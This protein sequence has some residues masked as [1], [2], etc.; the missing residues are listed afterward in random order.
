MLKQLKVK[1]TFPQICH[2][3]IKLYNVKILSRV[4]ISE[5]TQWKWMINIVVLFYI[6]TPVLF[7][8]L[9][10]PLPLYLFSHLSAFLI[11]SGCFWLRTNHFTSRSWA[12]PLLC[13]LTTRHHHH[14]TTRFV[15]LKENF[16][17]ASCVDMVFKRNVDGLRWI[18]VILFISHR[19]ATLPIYEFIKS[20]WCRDFFQYKRRLHA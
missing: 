7:T 15:A 19:R 16:N 1:W 13:S 5:P 11:W 2:E 14:C 9:F 17:S 20:T 8:F 3:D 10:L 12:S 18:C 4:Y 6:K